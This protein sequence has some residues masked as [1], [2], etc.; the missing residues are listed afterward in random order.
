MLKFRVWDK[1]TNK[2]YFPD[3]WIFPNHSG[4]GLL[5]LKEYPNTT[6]RG[7]GQIV[8]EQYIGQKDKNGK[9]IC[10]GDIVLFVGSFK[11]R[12]YYDDQRAAFRLKHLFVNARTRLIGSMFENMPVNFDISI[13]IVGNIHLDL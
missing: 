12:I 9:D 6:K 8:I 4:I 10:E 2:Y 3:I 5:G 11:A 1:E 13:E 7:Y